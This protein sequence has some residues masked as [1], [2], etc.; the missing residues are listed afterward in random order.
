MYKQR[1]IL[2]SLRPHQQHAVNRMW[3]VDKGQV[4]MATGS[5]KTMCMIDDT[6][7]NFQTTPYKTHVIVSPRILLTLQL[8]REFLEHIDNAF[9]CHVHSGDTPHFRTTKPD[10]I[11][12]MGMMTS[13][14]LIFTTYH[15]LHRIV[16]SGIKV[17][18]VYCDES[19]NSTR[20][21]FFPVVKQI[22]ATSDRIFYFTATPRHSCVDDKPGMN[23]TSVYGEIVSSATAKDMVSQGYILPPKLIA[24][25][26]GEMSTNQQIS[27]SIR[28]NNLQ[29]TLV[30][31]RSTAQLV[32]FLA[33]PE[34]NELKSDYDIFHITS[35]L[36]A[37]IN[38]KRVKRHTFFR[39]LREHK[40]KF[41]LLH[42]RILSEGINLSNLDSCVILRSMNTI[43]ILQ[44]IGRVIRLGDDKTHGKV[45][46]PTNDKYLNKYLKTLTH[47]VSETFDKGKV[48]VQ[49]IK[50]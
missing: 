16:E 35:Q 49:Y 47:I 18:T 39:R 24:S 28:V 22:S 26:E 19:H 7:A 50:R 6:I 14:K 45:I 33:S 23:D 12:M 41:I 38:G 4:I 10:E 3:D 1:V 17:D 25:G 2:Y 37:R 43:D 21:D 42:V 5:G 32:R 29:R 48:P 44:T 11:R 46:L 13:H 8:S 34:H 31:M 30:C 20:S 27:Q 36:G 9:V 40:G 15:S